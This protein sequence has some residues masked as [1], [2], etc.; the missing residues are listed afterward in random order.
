[1]TG[2][3]ALTLRRGVGFEPLR[4]PRPV[5]AA[6]RPEPQDKGATEDGAPPAPLP[7]GI[8]DDARA[9]RDRLRADQESRLPPLPRPK[10]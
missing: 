2:F 4:G 7:D 3:K 6:A 5:T 8:E 9:L 1:M 10:R